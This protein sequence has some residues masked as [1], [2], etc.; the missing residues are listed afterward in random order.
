MEKETGSYKDED[1]NDILEK[2]EAGAETPGGDVNV[3]EAFAVVGE[4]VDFSPNEGDNQ[5]GCAN[6]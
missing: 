5:I 2:N 4:D 6:L 3:T 1:A